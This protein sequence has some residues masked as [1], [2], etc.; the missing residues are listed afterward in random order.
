METY[1][2]KPVEIKAELFNPDRIEEYRKMW[3]EI[4]IVPTAFWKRYILPTLEW[5]VYITEDC[6]L[7]CWTK[8]EFYPCEKDIFEAKY[9]SEGQ[10]EKMQWQ[11][12][13]P[14]LLFVKTIWMTENKSWFYIFRN[15]K[16]N[17]YEL[18]LFNLA[19]AYSLSQ[20]F[21]TIEWAIEYA[22]SIKPKN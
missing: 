20:S 22:E 1:I 6:Y 5:N 16:D 19:W 4:E 12:K 13:N 7:I 8:W 21:D 3:A 2:A 17:N 10:I 9:I 11:I 15:V 18:R 14:Y